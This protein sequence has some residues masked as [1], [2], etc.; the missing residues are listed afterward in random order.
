MNVDT[1]VFK[2][3]VGTEFISWF[4]QEIGVEWEYNV[5]DEDYVSFNLMDLT[6]EEISR[7]VTKEKELKSFSFDE[8]E[9]LLDDIKASQF[10]RIND[11]LRSR[12]QVLM[13]MNSTGR[14]GS[15][16]CSVSLPDMG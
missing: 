12:C 5:M 8:Y 13:A 11:D 14:D 2:R 4:D 16:I 1:G 6:F 3:N 9:N 15:V 10:I 7:V